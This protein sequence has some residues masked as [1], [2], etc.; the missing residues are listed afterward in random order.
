MGKERI[1]RVLLTALDLLRHGRFK[2][3]G[4]YL[5]SLPFLGGL[6][7]L[8][9]QMPATRSFFQALAGRAWLLA[10]EGSY[11]TGTAGEK[12]RMWRA[13][14]DDVANNPLVGAG[15]D[16][17]MVHFPSTQ[18]GGSHNFSGGPTSKKRGTPPRANVGKIAPKRSG[19]RKG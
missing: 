18:G 14:L 16:T 4:L 11:R 15:Q 1:G 7:W 5:L 9:A 10:D 13:I 2:R 12:L 17:Y 6:F 19:K 8:T 3:L